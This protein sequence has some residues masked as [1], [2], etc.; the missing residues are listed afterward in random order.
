MINS[1]LELRNG[2][3]ESKMSDK[4][5]TNIIISIRFETCTSKEMESKICKPY[6]MVLTFCSDMQFSTRDSD[7][8]IKQNASCAQQ[9]KGAWWYSRCHHSN[10]NGLYL[11]G[12][13]SSMA[14]GVNWIPFK[15][16]YY[17][18]KRTEM[19]VK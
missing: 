18:L 15:G 13:H 4:L 11:N 3:V 1:S 16:Y 8:D 19:K 10:L 5:Q 6:F 17:S 14:D 7:N 2:V 12:S 9:F